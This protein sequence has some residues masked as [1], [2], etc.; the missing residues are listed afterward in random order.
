VQGLEQVRLADPVRADRENEPRPQVELEPLIRPEARELERLDN[1]EQA[2][3]VSP[4]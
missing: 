4:G 2:V 1:Q 3:D